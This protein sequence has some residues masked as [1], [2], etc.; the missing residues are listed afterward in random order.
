VR[1]HLHKTNRSY[2][3]HLLFMSIPVLVFI[4]ALF[5]FLRFLK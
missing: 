5:V 2:F 4:A 1:I 3:E